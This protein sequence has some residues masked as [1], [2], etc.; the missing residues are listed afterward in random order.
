MSTTLLRQ[1]GHQAGLDAPLAALLIRLN[2]AAVASA[3]LMLLLA[4]WGRLRRCHT[5]SDKQRCRIVAIL[6]ASYICYSASQLAVLLQPARTGNHIIDRMAAFVATFSIVF[7]SL[8]IAGAVGLDSAV[9]Y[10]LRSFGLARRLS[11][12]CEVACLVG[13]LTVSQPVLYLFATYTWTGS[14]VSISATPSAFEA[15]V[16]MTESAW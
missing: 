5:H 6:S 11:G 8:L 4:C 13:A 2:I 12:C 3:G 1:D 14:A 10:G 7:N 16:W 15:V 9:R